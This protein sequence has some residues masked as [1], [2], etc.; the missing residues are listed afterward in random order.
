MSVNNPRRLIRKS[1]IKEMTKSSPSY[2][3]TEVSSGCYDD[4]HNN[5]A[6]QEAEQPC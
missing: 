6:M 1:A 5:L 3:L 4:Q 2:S